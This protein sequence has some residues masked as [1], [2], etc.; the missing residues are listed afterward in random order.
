MFVEFPEIRNPYEFHIRPQF[1]QTTSGDQ[2]VIL[3]V[4]YESD[5][6]LYHGG[7]SALGSYAGG[8]ATLEIC[9]TFRNISER[10]A[11]KLNAVFTIKISN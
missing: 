2:P 8:V 6:K 11:T 3:P 9:L 7:R 10:T 4:P 1:V 5:G